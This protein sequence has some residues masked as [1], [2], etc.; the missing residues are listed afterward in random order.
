MWFMQYKRLNSPNLIWIDAK[1]LVINLIYILSLISSL[2][3]E[4][5]E[6]CKSH[7]QPRKK[8]YQICLKKHLGLEKNEKIQALVKW[9]SHGHKRWGINV[10]KWVERK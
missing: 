5:D 3:E 2:R 9:A 10:M 7:I 4:N 1:A 8:K 6:S